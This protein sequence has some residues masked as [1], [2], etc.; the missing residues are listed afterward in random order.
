MSFFYLSS[1]QLHTVTSPC[2]LT[3]L[4]TLTTTTTAAVFAV[5]REE[6]QKVSAYK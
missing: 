3:R 1:N 5:T 6:V 4:P 2:I